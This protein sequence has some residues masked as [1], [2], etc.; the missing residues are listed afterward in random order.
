MAKILNQI[1]S[2]K[3]GWEQAMAKLDE[4]AM[5]GDAATRVSMYNSF[6]K[7]GLSEREATFA[8]LEAM[9]FGRR[10]VS[11]TVFYANMMIPFFNAGLQGIDVLYRAF[12]NQMPAS[13]RLKVKQKLLARGAM[14]A[15]MTM[16]YAAVM[17]DEEEYKNA[18][19]DERYN[20]WLVPTPLGVLRVPIPFEAGLVFKGIPEGVYRMAFTD[21]KASDVMVAL[22]DLAMRSVPIDLRTA[23]KP[24][25]ELNLNKSFFTDR[26]IVDAS[27]PDDPK[28]QY[29]PNTPELIK[30]FG[31]VGLSP[32]QVEYFIKGYTGSL[33]VGL[34]RLFDPVLGGDLVKPDMRITDVPVLGGLFQPKD[35]GGLINAAYKSV[36]SIQAAQT[37]YNRLVIEDPAEAEKYLN[38]NLNNISLASFAGQFRQEM[39][40]LTAAERS[41][42]GAKTMTSEEKRKQLDDLRKMKIWLAASFND[43]KRQTELRASRG[44]LQ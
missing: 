4:W 40:E 1:S 26:E 28:Y 42:R 43:I 21:D 19:P 41:I 31:A 8:T 24:I 22:K 29:R 12:T 44:E 38:E 23:I 37:T 30:L 16:A 36:R 32:V 15:L 7:Q 14:M 35:A 6:I 2:G 18:N 34:T 33:L 5:M 27:M 25:V 39:G 11:P 3:A 10:G 17:E 20:N 9:N 13:E